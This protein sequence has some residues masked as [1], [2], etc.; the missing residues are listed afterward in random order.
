MSREHFDRLLADFL[1][2]A[3]GRELFAQDLYGGADPS[4]RVKT[5][6]F[7]EFAWHSLFI[8]NLLIRPEA[9][10][11]AAFAPDL[12]IV[13]LPSF[14]ADPKRHGRRT[15]TVIACDF[16]R[17]IVLIGGTSYAGEMK[18]SVFTYLNYMLAAKRGHADAL[19]G[20]FRRPAMTCDLLRPFRHRQDDALGRSDTAR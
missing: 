10:D 11:L 2:H 13:D 19:L 8:R 12:T 18:K 16:S 1:E 17:R 15:E 3:K 20:Q 5:R 7:T 4:F 6:V 14:R 9:G